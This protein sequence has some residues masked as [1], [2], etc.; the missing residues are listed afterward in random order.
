M[1]ELKFNCIKE[2][3]ED[4]YAVFKTNSMHGSTE[5]NLSLSVLVEE[6]TQEFGDMINTLKKQAM[7]DYKT[8]VSMI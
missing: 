2:K 5:I 7:H 4:R 6:D 1:K 3:K 8:S